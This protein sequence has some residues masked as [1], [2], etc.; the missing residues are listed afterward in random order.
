M[1]TLKHREPTGHKTI[2]WGAVALAVGGVVSTLSVGSLADAASSHKTKAIVVSTAQNAT[3]GTI[4]VSGKTLYTVKASKT[5]C[6]TQCQKFWL[7]LTLPRDVNKAKAG[8][9]VNAAKLGSVKRGSAR[10][11]TYGGKA[12]YWFAGDTAPGQVNGNLTNTWGKWSV[13]VVAKPTGATAPAVTTTTP[14]TQPGSSSTT[15]PTHAP[16]ITPA[17]TTT[18][19]ASVTV[20][21]TTTP[22]TSPPVTTTTSPPTTTTTTSGGTGGV[23]F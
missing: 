21:P 4:L 12:L 23:G 11:V 8:A 9:G 5:T 7:G 6:R 1:H 10:Q 18:P 22:M 20:P 17:P 14:T 15:T 16:T 13:V 19:S 2:R 3:Y